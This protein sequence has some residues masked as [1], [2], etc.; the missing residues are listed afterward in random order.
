MCHRRG[1]PPTLCMRGYHVGHLRPIPHRIDHVFADAELH[2]G[3]VIGQC[4]GLLDEHIVDALQPMRTQHE[5]LM[6]TEYVGRFIAHVGA[7]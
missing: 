6:A 3:I 5:G 7:F 1:V 2:H 4:S